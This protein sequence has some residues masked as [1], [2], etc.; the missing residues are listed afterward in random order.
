MIYSKKIIYTLEDVS[1]TVSILPRYAPDRD[2]IDL[3]RKYGVD[4]KNGT[5]TQNTSIIY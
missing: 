5:R 4:L 3:G 2:W 1:E